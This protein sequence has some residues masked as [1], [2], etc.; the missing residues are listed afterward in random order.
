MHLVRRASSPLVFVEPT[1]TLDEDDRNV[2]DATRLD[3][4]R[5]DGAI[6]TTKD[7]PAASK[8]EKHS[9]SETA[10]APFVLFKLSLLG[11]LLA[12]HPQT[13]APAPVHEFSPLGTLRPLRLL[14]SVFR[15]TSSST[16]QF[17]KVRDGQ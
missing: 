10:Q 13:V 17:L 4:T 14:R 7:L 15:R 11:R 9:T 2:S 6:A 1:A 16:V 8:R 3:G 5:R 12:L